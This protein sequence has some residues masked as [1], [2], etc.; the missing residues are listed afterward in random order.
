MANG[1][2]MKIKTMPPTFKTK[3]NKERKPKLPLAAKRKPIKAK[4][5]NVKMRNKENEAKK[6]DVTGSSAS[7]YEVFERP[8]IVPEPLNDTG[9]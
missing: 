4:N 8:L 5:C 7:S 1:K 9:T 6:Q 2:Q 3:L